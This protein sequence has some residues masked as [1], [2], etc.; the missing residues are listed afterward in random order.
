[1]ALTSTMTFAQTRGKCSATE[2][3]LRAIE[4]DPSILIKEAAFEEL[5]KAKAQEKDQTKGVV[6]TIPVVIHVIH[7]GEAVGT[8]SN[9]SDADAAAI[10]TV[11]NEQFRKTNADTLWPGDP[12]Y[13]LSVDTEIEFCLAQRDPQGNPT[14]GITRMQGSQ[15]TWQDF[16][17]DSL[18]KPITIWDH[19]SYMNMWSCDFTDPSLDGYGTF[20]AGVAADKDGIVVSYNDFL[21]P[22]MGNKS[23]VATHEV[24]HYLNL[25]HIWGDDQC[26][27]DMV[28]DTPPAETDNSGCPNYP[29]NANSACG[30][31]PD[32]EMFMNYMDYSD[33]VCTMVYTP[34]QTTRMRT[35]LETFRS[36]LLTSDACQPL[37]G[38]NS[39]SSNLFSVYPNPNQGVFVIDLN[40]NSIGNVSI[41]VYDQLG[42]EVIQL[43]NVVQFPVEVT[44]EDVP[45]G[46]YYVKIA[47]D[48]SVSNTKVS[49]LK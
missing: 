31:G 11:M 8:G 6:Y 39:L 27:D 32:G 22:N 3:R 24:G 13:D 10:I 40:D 35:T 43:S 19:T 9:L 49:V 15:A 45:N 1:M 5:M 12:F 23:I 17:F 20:P 42:Q 44:L 14:S 2:T 46:I 33:A 36:G 7:N 37:M 4:K 28:A 48:Q 29:H 18:V 21:A 38:V 26:G 41:T 34:D 30:A 25:N 47:N 16:E